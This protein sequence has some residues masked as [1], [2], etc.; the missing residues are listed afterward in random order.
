[1]RFRPAVPGDLPHLID[2]LLEAYNWGGVE[3]FTTDQLAL[4]DNAWRYIDGWPRAGE[5]GVIAAVDGRR[6][7]AVWA[8]LMPSSRPGYGYVADDVPEL[9]LG[10]V[11]EFRGQGVGRA[12]LGEVITAARLAGYERLS[13]SVEPENFAAGLYRSVGFEVV[14]RNGGSD[15]MVLAL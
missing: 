7:G 11:A 14:G 6:A 9:S 15:T 13:L 3:R 2:M 4:N 5:F 12:L 10:V 8:R 1:M